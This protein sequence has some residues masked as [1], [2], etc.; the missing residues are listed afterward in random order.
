MASTQPNGPPATSPRLSRGGKGD[1]KL[2]GEEPTRGQ[3]RDRN[4]RYVIRM[5]GSVG[6]FWRVCCGGGSGR[7]S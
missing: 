1:M 3:A 5:W 6:S 2:M 4:R 7:L